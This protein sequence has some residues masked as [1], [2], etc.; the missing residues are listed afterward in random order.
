MTKWFSSAHKLNTL[1]VGTLV[2]FSAEVKFSTKWRK[3][4]NREGFVTDDRV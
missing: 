1:P 3:V 2:T 4:E